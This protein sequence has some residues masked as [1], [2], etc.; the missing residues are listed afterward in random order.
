MAGEELFI[1]GL[2]IGVV[3]VFLV[4]FLVKDKVLEW[5]SIKF[6]GKD[7]CRVTMIGR[8][9]QIYKGIGRMADDTLEFRRRTWPC[10]TN[11]IAYQ[12]K[13][14]HIIVYEDGDQVQISRQGHVSPMTPETLDKVIQMSLLSGDVKLGQQIKRMEQF[15]MIGMLA[16]VGSAVLAWQVLTILQG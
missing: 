9:R 12:E 1:V 7:A 15:L 5:K 14:P 4:L 13:L 6:Y 3:P 2:L 8:N 16:S 10:D 11:E